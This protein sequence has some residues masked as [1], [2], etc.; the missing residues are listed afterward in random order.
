MSVV[1][2]TDQDPFVI[3]LLA[4]LGNPKNVANIVIRIPAGGALT[5]EVE[6]FLV[7]HE[8]VMDALKTMTTKYNLVKEDN[9]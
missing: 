4:A 7:D 2:G 9:T 1:T 3:D 6:Q 5:I 8:P